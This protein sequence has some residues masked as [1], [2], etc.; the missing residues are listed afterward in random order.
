MLYLSGEAGNVRAI[1]CV[2]LV[3]PTVSHNSLSWSTE[4]CSHICCLDVRRNLVL[5]LLSEVTRH[6]SVLKVGEDRQ[7]N[8]KR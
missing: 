5:Y 6:A 3:T 2:V 8:H 7:E 1:R 4:N